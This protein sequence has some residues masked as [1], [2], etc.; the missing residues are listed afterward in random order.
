MGTTTPSRGPPRCLAFEG[1]HRR[2][3]LPPHPLRRTLEP[4][5]SPML[6]GPST[7]SGR[8][9]RH[10]NRQRHPVPREHQLSG[11]EV[12]S[13]DLSHRPFHWT[14]LRPPPV[15]GG[16]AGRLGGAQA[17]PC[18]RRCI[19]SPSRPTAG[20]VSIGRAAADAVSWER[21]RGAPWL[22]HGQRH[23]R[24]PWVGRRPG[25]ACP[26]GS[27]GWVSWTHAFRLSCG[28]KGT[29]RLGRCVAM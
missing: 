6:K 14:C 17:G 9:L 8:W 29:S 4:E 22:P 24:V 3:L 12:A 5:A 7:A 23:L 15:V 25:P 2:R 10:G 18:C 28:T 27:T 13:P 20:P 11:D 21:V 19:V 16:R 1:L 26:A